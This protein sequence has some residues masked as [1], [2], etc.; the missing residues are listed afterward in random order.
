MALHG[1]SYGIGH[2]SSS[3]LIP[4]RETSICL[5]GQ[6]KKDQKKKSCSHIQSSGNREER[7]KVASLGA[8]MPD[9]VLAP[10]SDGFLGTQVRSYPGRLAKHPGEMCKAPLQ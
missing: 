8:C 9:T 1:H 2:S 5:W 7:L 10:P 3:D 6:P 4:G